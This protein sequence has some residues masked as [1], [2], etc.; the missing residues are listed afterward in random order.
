MKENK[1]GFEVIKAYQD[2]SIRLPQR[3]TNYSAG[4]D[5]EA[6]ETVVLPS[7]WKQSVYYL[8]HNT[9]L[10]MNDQI[11]KKPEDLWQATLVPTGLK[12]YMMEDEY[13]KI[14]NRSSGSYKHQTALPNG[15]GIIDQDYY[16]NKKNEGHIYV[17][18][19]NY[20]LRDRT[21]QK[22][23]RIA[24]GIFSKF[25]LVEDDQVVNHERKGGFGSSD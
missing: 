7:F 18:L 1:R 22:G 20:G 16:N 25:L 2:K 21:I 13:L 14:V 24:Q 12:A 6:A 5:L 3:Q 15:I 17:Q 19:I 8:L 10:K 11:S 9:F 4:Y 23:E